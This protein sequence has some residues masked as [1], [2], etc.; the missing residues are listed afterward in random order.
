MSNR[1]MTAC[2]RPARRQYWIEG[3]R[4]VSYERTDGWSLK[5]VAAAIW[6]LRSPAGQRVNITVRKGQE[7]QS[8]EAAILAWE[9]GLALRNGRKGDNRGGE[10]P[11]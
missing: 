9:A 1:F 7:T 2:H 8:A 11:A 6:S 10:V 3:A 4:K 5:L